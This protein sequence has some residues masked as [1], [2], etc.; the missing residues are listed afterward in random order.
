MAGRPGGRAGRDGQAQA[1]AGKLCQGLRN[2]QVIIIVIIIIIIIIIM[3]VIMI[4]V[5]MIIILYAMLELYNNI[6]INA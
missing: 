6:K 4:I 5:I 3:I 1:Q 2:V